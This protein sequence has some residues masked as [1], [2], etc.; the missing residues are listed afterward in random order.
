MAQFHAAT[1]AGGAWWDRHLGAVTALA[2]SGK[3]R[4]LY[5][6]GQGISEMG[7]FQS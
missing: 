7:S 1:R 6:G 3:T 2:H 5:S 4:A